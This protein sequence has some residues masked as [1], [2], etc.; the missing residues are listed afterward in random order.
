MRKF[1]LSNELLFLTDKGTNQKALFTRDY[2]T[3][4]KF[5]G[6]LRMPN[7]RQN[8][9]IHISDYM[10][11]YKDI[12]EPLITTNTNLSAKSIIFNDTTVVIQG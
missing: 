2:I 12:T 9:N 10:M 11:H 1:T 3:L 7:I 8:P 6:V 4:Y 5:K